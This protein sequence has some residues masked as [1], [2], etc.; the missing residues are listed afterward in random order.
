MNSNVTVIVPAHNEAERIT[1]TLNSVISQTYRPDEII[2]VDDNSDDD[3]VNFARKAL[4]TNISW[5]V[6]S[7]IGGSKAKAQNAALPYVRTKYVIAID[8]DTILA[9]DAI[10]KI[11]EAMDREHAVAASSWVMTQRQN[12]WVQKGRTI[13][14]LF[15]F[16]WFKKVQNYYQRPLIASGCFNIYQT[17][18]LRAIGGY[19]EDTLAEDMNATWEIYKR[20]LGRVLFVE[21]ALAYTDDPEKLGQLKNQLARWSC[22]YFQN[23]KKHHDDLMREDWMAGFLLTTQMVNSVMGSIFYLIILGLFFVDPIFALLLLSVDICLIGV[24]AS[25][26]GKRFGLEKR[27]WLW[28]PS[29]FLVTVINSY[30]FLKYMMVTGMLNKSIKCYIKGH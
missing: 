26:G 14:Y 4:R 7:T 12:T 9:K 13:E 18:V 19:P 29:W 25:I 8:A 3:T 27:V 21:D 30:Y 24:V 28:I 11:V 1:A 15:S 2:V 23:Y 20:H 6:L 17:K 16:V 22:A 5:R 10:E